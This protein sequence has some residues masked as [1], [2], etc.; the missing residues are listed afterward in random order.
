MIC[1]NNLSLCHY[2][3]TQPSLLSMS[4]ADWAQEKKL[5]VKCIRIQ[6]QLQF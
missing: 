5:N 6:N 1:K 2:A 3:V 4:T